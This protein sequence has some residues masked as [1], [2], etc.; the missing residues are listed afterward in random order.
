M[1]HLLVDTFRLVLSDL[2]EGTSDYQISDNLNLDDNKKVAKAQNCSKK[3]QIIEK[4][5]RHD[6]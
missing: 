3:K 5:N 1:L 6:Y 2:N 4:W